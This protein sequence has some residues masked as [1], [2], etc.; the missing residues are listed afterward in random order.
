MEWRGFGKQRTEKVGGHWWTAASCSGRT[1]S[2]IEYTEQ[3]TCT[4]GVLEY[5]SDI[6]CQCGRAGCFVKSHHI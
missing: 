4:D 2:R 5:I 6:R 3:M 1:Q